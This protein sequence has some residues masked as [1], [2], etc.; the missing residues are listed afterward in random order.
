MR[1]IL[2]MV[3]LFLNSFVFGQV[4]EGF[5]DGEVL[6]QPV[7]MGDT[8]RFKVNNANQLQSRTFNRT[9]TAYLATNNHYLL[10]TTWEFYTQ[11]NVDPSSS[12]QLRFYLAFDRPEL[13]SSGNGYFI[14]I[15][16][17][18]ATDSYDLYR[19]SGKSI[20]KIID[21]PPKIRAKTDTLK[22]YFMVIHRVDG[23]WELYSRSNPT[24][25][26]TSEGNCMERVYRNTNYSGI[27]IKYTSTRADKFI[28]D[29][30]HIY[31]YDVD[32]SGPEY[33]DIEI[34]DDT[35]VSLLFSEELDTIGL[36]NLNAFSLNNIFHSKKVEIDNINKSMINLIFANT[37]SG[38]RT[39]IRFPRVSDL[40]GNL[41][42]S[43]QTVY[44]NY[45][46][47]FSF[48]KYDIFFSEIM[49]DPSPAV[50]LPDAEY[51]EI[52]NSTNTFFNFHGWEYQNGTSK[53]KLPA[54]TLG[55]KETVIL[56][57]IS[58]TSLFAPYGKYLGVSTWP[59]IVNTSGN[60]KLL[61]DKGKVIDEV[62]YNTAWYKNTSKE[63]GGY[64]LECSQKIKT[65]SGFY[66]WEA[67]NSNT[68]GTPGKA[69]S[70]WTASAENLYVQQLEFLTDT[71]VHIKFNTAPDTV[72]TK[73]TA[74]YWLKTI[75]SYPT[76]LRYINNRFDEVILTYGTKVINK[77]QY[78]F[79][80][81]NI[82]TCNN[83]ILAENSFKMVFINND[84]TSKIRINEVYVD[85]YP[86]YGLPENEYVELFNASLN[87]VDLSGYSFYIGS[88]RYL[89]PKYLLKTNEYV[90]LCS[91]ADTT[92]MK[93]FGNCIG[94]NSLISLSNT[95][96]TLSI[97]NKV[98]RLIDRITY[99]QSW[100]RDNT[101]I[102]GG[103]SL[104]LIDPYNRCDFINRWNASISRQGGT[105]GIKNSV[106]DFYI[107][108][109][110]LAI[111]SFQNINGSQFKIV[112]NKAIDG[113]AIN[114]AQIYFVGAKL[115]LYFP[116]KM[117]ID[118]PYYQTI[119]ITFTQPIPVGKYNLVCQ[120]LPSCSRE[121]TNLVLQVNITSVANVLQ[122]I[123]F[124]EL[125]TDPS[126][127]VGLP[128][129]EY[130]ELYNKS[131]KNLESVNFYLAD[132]KDTIPISIENWKANE[133]ILFCHKE[134]RYSWD[135]LVRIYPLNKMLSLGNEFDSLSI[136][137]EQKNLISNFNYSYLQL[138]TEK[139][140][141]GYS[142]SK[143]DN[144]WEC[145]SD[146][147]WQAS[148]N[149][150]GGSPGFR[151]ESMSNYTL[152][153][154][155]LNS[156]YFN[157]EKRIVCSFSPSIEKNA[158]IKIFNSGFSPFNYRLNEKN[159]LEIEL[160]NALSSGNIY[161]LNIQIEN[162]LGMYIDTTLTIYKKY[163][164]KNM[165]II[166]S[167]ILFNPSAGGVDFIEVYNNSDSVIDI[168]DI[169]ISDGK[170][171]ILLNK[172]ITKKNENCYIQPK[173]YRVI[174]TNNTDIIEH[175]YVDNKNH[176]IQ[177]TSLPSMPDDNGTIL[178]QNEYGEVLDQLDYDESFHLKWLAEIEGRSIE[179]KRFEEET[180]VKE[181]W[182]SA[183]DDV[184]R[185]TPTGKNS[186]FVE[187]SDSKELRF[188]L[189]KEV[190]NPVKNSTEN[191]LEINYKIEE[192]AIFTNVKLFS[193]SGAYLG[194][195]ITGRSI[196][197]AGYLTWD[198]ST[199]GQLIQAGTYI[200]VIECYTE[201]GLNEF[202]KIPFVIHY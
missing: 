138:P 50:G 55:A 150:K 81:K 187:N 153:S 25:P 117:V 178:I 59:S 165:D 107:D 36:S 1:K 126:P 89:L 104:E 155:K 76:K 37:I 146:Y 106:A 85:P 45:A 72:K 130:I 162:C 44:V 116:Q 122:N 57:K 78:T 143:I 73:N 52:Y 35:V 100:Y 103:W 12:N 169:T 53:I 67:S 48:N 7:W 186:Q 137:D 171:S 139:R 90:L 110:N 96:A 191:Q 11:I 38:G 113:R 196:R 29:D 173:E 131:E 127:S 26:W 114:P 21:G 58:D 61:D 17:T 134:F 172:T 68:G 62:S 157:S 136:L 193:I 194:E 39:S 31:P 142:F 88:T 10:N 95:S 201:K 177:S 124:S 23:L 174:S 6:H 192:D 13:D 92:E 141:G 19:K 64:S 164:P 121:D 56:C 108:K 54:Y 119:V 183:T 168:N 159:E 32:T 65:C 86:S 198:M 40:L 151:N 129:A 105:P 97:T 46:A 60:L 33:T 16:E 200:L 128:D 189:S 118:S 41:S 24:L 125:M 34:H 166:I 22:A 115:K 70:S 63:A 77:K 30:I 84:D 49:A 69:N 197:N 156:Y 5:N 167:E 158:N 195:I 9:D 101:K 176:L 82:N 112:L 202:Y 79:E 181:N 20:T 163:I 179:R 94:I 4:S 51:L 74:N 43:A 42:D 3:G 185:A 99:K 8:G 152:P 109:K 80:L 132:T 188:W 87:N 135:S 161:E 27:S 190:L 154:I 2:W 91:T 28:L 145:E 120:Y 18:G 184:G 98:G 182:S 147:T 83:L 75:N 102:D 199:N 14:Q 149:E 180:N 111:A 15:G 66:V 148:T 160:K 71:T 47:P 175:F 144:T 133:Y 170:T 93:K 140:E 123:A